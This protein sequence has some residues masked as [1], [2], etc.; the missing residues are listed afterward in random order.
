VIEPPPEK[1]ENEPIVLEITDTLDLHSF[2]PSEVKHVLRDYLDAAWEQ[3][4]RELR[5]VHG[6]G[7]GVQRET[8]RRTLERDPRVADF[9]DAPGAAGGWGATLVLLGE[10]SGR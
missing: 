7:I 6:R 9:G 8:V 10:S 2:R 1:D 4:L 3:G 5:I